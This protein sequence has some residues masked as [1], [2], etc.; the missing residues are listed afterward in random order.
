ML[1]VACKESA[2]EKAGKVACRFASRQTRATFARRHEAELVS[3]VA[4]DAEHAFRNAILTRTARPPTYPAP[5]CR[6]RGW[7]MPRVYYE[8]TSVPVVDDDGASAQ[9]V[10]STPVVVCGPPGSAE[11]RRATTWSVNGAQT[12]PVSATEFETNAGKH[13]RR[14]TKS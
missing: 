8:R 11:Q 13:W 3:S 9:L 6:I 12:H 7:H 1:A 2:A 10:I 14:K 5:T 4:D